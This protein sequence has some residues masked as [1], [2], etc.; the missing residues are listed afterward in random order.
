MKV[1]KTVDIGREIAKRTGFQQSD[2]MIVVDEVF[3][4]IL[5]ALTR[6][7]DVM[8]KKFGR[9]TLLRKKPR[10]CTDARNG[11]KTMSN[12]KAVIKFKQSE[13]IGNRLAILT[14]PEYDWGDI[15]E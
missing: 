13:M 6:G 12:Y 15:E 10:V 1:I 8:V 5:E 2:V 4:I 11:K 9:F 14:N 7:D 3:P